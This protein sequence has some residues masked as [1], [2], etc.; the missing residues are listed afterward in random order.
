MLSVGKSSRVK[1]TAGEWRKNSHSLS[2]SK[3]EK[4]GLSLHPL[5]VVVGLIYALQGDLFLFLLN[6][7][8]ALQHELAHA[9]ASAKLGYTMRKIVLMP[10]GAV[11]EGDLSGISLKDEITV[12]LYGPLCNLFTALLFG[13]IWWFHP[14]VYAFTDTVYYVSLSVALVNLLPAY[15]LDGGRV[16][17][18][19]L[20]RS[21]A[22]SNPDVLRAEQKAYTVCKAVSLIFGTILVAVGLSLF[23][24]K[25]CNISLPIFGLFLWI[26]ALSV[27]HVSSYEKVNFSSKTAL[28]KGVEVRHVAVDEERTLKDVFRFLQ[29]GTFLVLDVYNSEERLVFSITQNELWEAFSRA[30]TPYVTLKQLHQP[31]FWEKE[32][33]FPTFL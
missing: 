30:D 26:S 5:F 21:F 24:L 28:K 7:L 20:T 31:K 32:E 4:F 13:A 2:N 8:V 19:V 23:F 25:K 22:K 18:A 29:A 11:L 16:L 12:A 14:T 27:S 6:C 33:Q 1:R 10:F 17:R 15:P 9:F 3:P